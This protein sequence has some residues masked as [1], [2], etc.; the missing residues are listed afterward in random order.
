MLGRGTEMVNDFDPEDSM[1]QL[2]NGEGNPSTHVTVATM[3]RRALQAPAYCPRCG[4]LMP[5]V[6]G[7]RCFHCE[8]TPVVFFP[9]QEV[10][11]ER[12]AA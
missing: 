3:L 1:G 10:G 5:P 9:A 6:R 11:R 8:E 7:A 2:L 12:V 4:D